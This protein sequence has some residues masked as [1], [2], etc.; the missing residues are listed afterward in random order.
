M[1]V[2][3]YTH[4]YYAYICIHV[5]IRMCTLYHV[6]LFAG[7]YMIYV[8]VCMCDVCMLRD[9]PFLCTGGVPLSLFSFFSLSSPS[10]PLSQIRAVS[11]SLSHTHSHSHPFS[12]ASPLRD[13]EM[14][15]TKKK[16]RKSRGST[17][18]PCPSTR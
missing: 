12:L 1:Y 15:T 17:R 13:A 8:V 10:W 4:T 2:C 18:T 5:C 9:A 11:L 3:M 16:Q 14:H 6:L 7:V